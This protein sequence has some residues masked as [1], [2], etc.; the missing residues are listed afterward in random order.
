MES[1]KFCR[2]GVRHFLAQNVL[3]YRK[4]LYPAG[5]LRNACCSFVISGDNSYFF[6]R[7]AYGPDLNQASRQKS[8]HSKVRK[9]PE[10]R[11]S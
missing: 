9:S 4:S 10:K 8:T 5:V 2:V 7:N 11:E 1:V 3:S 6:T